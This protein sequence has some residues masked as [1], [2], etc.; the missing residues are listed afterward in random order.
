MAHDI[1]PNAHYA[2]VTVKLAVATICGDTAA[3]GLNELLNP[4]IGEGFI[5][6]YALLHTDRPI[7]VESSDVPE[8][9]ELFVNAS[10]WLVLVKQDDYV[11][12]YH[13]VDSALELHLMAQS[14]LIEML[15]EKFVIEQ[16]A[17]VDV[18]KLDEMQ[19]H[20]V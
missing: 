6:D 11:T 7:I 10:T 2:V 8:E 14:E 17:H 1:Q 9:G 19:R 16:G 15:R 3:D 12:A 20:L 4:E 5:A 18:L 13:R